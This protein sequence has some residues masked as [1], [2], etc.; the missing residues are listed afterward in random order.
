M[1]EGTLEE[2]EAYTKTELNR[3]LGVGLSPFLYYAGPYSFIYKLGVHIQGKLIVI[4]RDEI[5][6]AVAEVAKNH[7]WQKDVSTDT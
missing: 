2:Y 5:K 4:E 7:G 6:E 1:F 3:E